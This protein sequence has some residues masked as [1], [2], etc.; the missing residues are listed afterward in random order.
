MKR[1]ARFYQNP[2]VAA[3]EIRWYHGGM[4]A[5]KTATI[6]ELL[7]TFSSHV[8]AEYPKPE[9]F[10]RNF[11][12]LLKGKRDRAGEASYIASLERNI[13]FLDDLVGEAERFLDRLLRNQEMGGG[14]I[15]SALAAM[16]KEVRDRT[17]KLHREAFVE[18][19][20]EDFREL[21]GQRKAGGDA[22]RERLEFNY[23]Y[24]MTVRILV[25]ELIAVA[26]AVVAEYRIS[27]ENPGATAAEGETAAANARGAEPDAATRIRSHIEL[28]THYYLGNVSIGEKPRETPG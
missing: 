21:A 11:D 12:L 15:E 24:L 19:T 1:A 4:N 3:S 20:D 28:M 8:S 25:F 7:A 14:E 9:D 16:E 13:V 27:L 5:G 2:A 18:G 17:A 6:D 26:A 10:R 23:R 22:Y